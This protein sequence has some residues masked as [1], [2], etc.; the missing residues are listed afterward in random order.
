MS[1]YESFE[2]FPTLKDE[3]TFESFPT[4]S[5]EFKPTTN[6]HEVSCGRRSSII[7]TCLLATG[8]FFLAGVK[9]TYNN[10]HGKLAYN[11]ALKLPSIR[12]SSSTDAPH[13]IFILADDLGWNSIG[14][15]DYDLSFATPHLT[16]LAKDGIILANYYSQEVCTPGRAA[17]LTGRYPLSIGMQYGVVETDTPWGLNLNETT[18]AE[19][20]KLNG[21]ATHMLGKW[22][23]GHHSPQ[24]LPTA[25]GFDT[26]TGYFDGDNY[27]YSKRNP[28][29][30]TFFDFTSS[31]K[32][33]YY[34]YVNPNMHNYSTHLYRDL[35]INIIN[36]H[37]ST[38]PLFL[39]L[40]F[41]AVH[42]PFEDVTDL[43]TVSSEFIEKDIYDKILTD[44]VV[45]LRYSSSVMI[46]I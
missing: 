46:F 1:S 26:F 28:T 30:D 16:A 13:I 3:V 45:S 15:Y 8:C 14:Y 38:V 24:Y 2:S 36:D 41:Q 11:N 32:D 4:P 9:L 35:A 22:H 7:L 31:D 20:L 25:R 43:R 21:Y 42:D 10:A 40:S 6:E 33:C 19:V 37:K 27:Y 44:V 12:G 29:K 34:N 39:Y 23:L 5:E 18:L 17:L